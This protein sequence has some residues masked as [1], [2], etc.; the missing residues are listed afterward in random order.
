MDS[1]GTYPVKFGPAMRRIIDFENPEKSLSILPTGQSGYF[2]APHY[3]DQA[4]LY[5]NNLFRPQ[6]MNKQ[7]IIM[8]STPP[9]ILK[10]AN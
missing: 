8:K 6:L 10:P 4:E 7:E 9:F 1:T 3:K 2:F 5:N